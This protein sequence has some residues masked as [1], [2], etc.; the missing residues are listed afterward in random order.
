MVLGGGVPTKLHAAPGQLVA[1][2]ARRE[3][4]VSSK[5]ELIKKLATVRMP[6][7]FLLR[8]GSY[9]LLSLKNLIVPQGTTIASL[10]AEKPAVFEGM[11]IDGVRGLTV[12]SLMIRPPASG[13]IV[14]R[15]GAMI[16]NS[17]NIELDR[18]IFKGPN[19]KSWS[20]FNVALMLRS[21]SN[22]KVRRS[23]FSQFKNGI[24]ILKLQHAVIELNEFENLQTDAIRGGGSNN[25]DISSNVIT[26]FYPKN[27]DHPDGIQLWST[28]Q[29]NIASNISISDNLIVRGRG[30]AIQGVF[31][32]DTK[33]RLPFKNLKIAGNLVIG[34]LY[35][36]ITVLGADRV[37]LENNTVISRKDQKSWIRLE[38]TTRARA[39]GNSAQSYVIERNRSKPRL[40][41]NQ[42]SL[43]TN[44]DVSKSISRWVRSKEAF[45][46]YRGPVLQRI[47]K[48]G[49]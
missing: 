18:L 24:A 10:H 31:V 22:I 47:M 33:L 29:R 41:N 49:R 34:G 39:T 17:Q 11:R 13:P 46:S 28:R 3:V 21:S 40:A 5:A 19:T 4:V 38:Y 37:A 20:N 36:G 9:G 35:N 15:Y 1:D 44:S 25:L 32:R 7:K 48:Q 43:A 12:S 8:Q 45:A 2:D 30:T 42:T 14:G 6:T 27:G 23:Y 26:G 16:T